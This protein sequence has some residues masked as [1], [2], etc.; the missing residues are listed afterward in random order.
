[1]LDARDVVFDIQKPVEFTVR[2]MIAVQPLPP[3]RVARLG[4]DNPW[5]G[6]AVS[7]PVTILI[8]SPKP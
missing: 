2:A 7:K 4:F 6:R 8:S 1:M 3:V 5:S